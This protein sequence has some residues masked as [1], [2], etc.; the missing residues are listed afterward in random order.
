M[1]GYGRVMP[2]AGTPAVAF[3]VAGRGGT[4]EIGPSSLGRPKAIAPMRRAGLL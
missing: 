4:G 1:R 2:V 3:G